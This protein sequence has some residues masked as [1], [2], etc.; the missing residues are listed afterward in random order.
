[1]EACEILSQTGKH[2]RHADTLKRLGDIHTEEG[3]CAEAEESYRHAQTIF[4]SLED[5]HGEARV[6]I[7]L[8]VLYVR[9]DR[10]DEAEECFAQAR[11]A[12]AMVAD[13]DG[14][15]EALKSLMGVYFFQRKF[16]DLKVACME[17]C[18]MYTQRG[19]S[20]SDMCAHT[21]EFLQALEKLPP[22]L[23]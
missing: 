11:V 6:L 21:W 23:R 13:E 22:G 20:M 19:Q 5:A 3:A 9:Q 14:E 17:A 18:E 7:R 1:M 4:L 15:A 2:A 16:D 12:Y 10:H 8:G